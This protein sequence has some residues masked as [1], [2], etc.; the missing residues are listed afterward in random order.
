MLEIRRLLF[1]CVLL[2]IVSYCTI[3]FNSSNALNTSTSTIPSNSSN[4][5]NT[6]TIKGNVKDIDGTACCFNLSNLTL[7][8]SEGNKICPDNTCA[9]ELR[10]GYFAITILIT[11]KVEN[12][13]KS[14]ESVTSFDYYTISGVFNLVHSNETANKREQMLFYKGTL[15]IHPQAS[16][17]TIA[18][19]DSQ[20]NVILNNLTG[21]FVLTGNGKESLVNMAKSQ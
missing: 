18:E 11:L 16:S 6:I 1:L 21:T 19:Y 9:M 4:A 13:T 5:L 15:Y 10:D 17:E 7:F 3:P 20:I 2:L 14:D 12:K 8:F